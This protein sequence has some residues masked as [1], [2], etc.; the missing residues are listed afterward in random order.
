MEKKQAVF[1]DTWYPGTAVECEGAIRQFLKEGR[2]RLKGDFF[3][4]IVPHAGWHFSGSIAARVIGSLLPGEGDG[5][6]A[7]DTVI[8][9]G[10]HMH[11]QA[12]PFIMTH[13]DIQTPFGDI[14]VDG[15]LT[16]QIA[17]SAG[18]WKKSP[19]KFP[20]E[21][22]LE[23]QY[24]FIKYFFPNAKI[25][26]CGVPPNDLAAV[27]GGM[28]VEKAKK[29]GRNI[30]VIGSTDMTHYGP[31]FG[32]TLAGSGEGAVEWVTMENDR[33]AI[34]AMKAMDP[35]GVIAQGLD[36]KNMCCPGAVAATLAACKKEGA[37]KA[38]ELDYAT[39]FEKSRS[40]SFVGYAGMLY[41][42]A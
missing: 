27:I 40:D 21:N 38:V 3:G 28:A 25:V 6:A 26:V 16:E 30:R 36:H 14:E 22:T 5:F 19:E 17:K 4:G 15:E 13:G 1:A 39:S 42:R 23:L 35:A 9:F 11:R 18:V 33:N 32:F 10:V 37:A 31:D 8:L 2:G 7:I 29:M 24:P 34:A 20:D 41:A 12:T